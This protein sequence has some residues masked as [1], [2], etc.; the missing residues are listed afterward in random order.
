PSKLEES[1]HQSERLDSESDDSPLTPGGAM[2]SDPVEQLDRGLFWVEAAGDHV[3]D[4]RTLHQM[5]RQF[6]RLPFKPSNDR[7]GVHR[8][9]HQ[10]LHGPSPP[11]LE[12]SYESKKP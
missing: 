8:N 7:I 10:Y 5:L 6:M 1:S 12:R 3:N 9:C 2:N 4:M 11:T